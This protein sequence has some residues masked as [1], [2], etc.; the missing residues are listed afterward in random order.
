M[1]L[2]QIC[3]TMIRM[4]RNGRYAAWLALAAIVSLAGCCGG[5]STHKCDFTPP[6]TDAGSGSD[7]GQSCGNLTCAAGQVCCFTK[8]PPFVSCI[9]PKDYTADGCEKRQTTTPPCATPHDCDAGAVCCLYLNP[10]GLSCQLPAACAGDG[11][12]SYRTCGSD[13][14]CPRVA[15]GVCQNVGAGGGITLNVCQP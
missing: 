6:P 5:G 13:V 4:S 11:T 9:D 15:P 7:A 8:T 3:G 10:Q 12:D 1:I 14:D 2:S